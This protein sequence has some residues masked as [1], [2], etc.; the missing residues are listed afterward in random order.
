M[1]PTNLYAAMRTLCS[2][3]SLL[4]LFFLLLVTDNTDWPL[5]TQKFFT[6]VTILFTRYAACLTSIEASDG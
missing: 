1:T 2:F 6:H 3:T 4:L 5:R